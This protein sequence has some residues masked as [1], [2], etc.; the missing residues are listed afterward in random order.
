MRQ[1]SGILADN[2]ELRKLIVDNPDLPIVVLCGENS[3]SG[4]YSWIYASDIRFRL[5]EILDCD[6]PVNEE[7]VYSDRQEFYEDL[8]EWLFDTDGLKLL[9][10]PEDVKQD[11]LTREKAKYERYWKKCIMI[12]ADN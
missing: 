5:G 8:E 2:T 11:I 1:V 6:Q 7:R 12:F 10:N 4:E 3:N 9:E